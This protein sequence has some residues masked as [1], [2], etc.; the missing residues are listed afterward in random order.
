MPTCEWCIGAGRTK[1]QITEYYCYNSA[2]VKIFSLMAGGLGDATQHHSR[3]YKTQLLIACWRFD[4]MAPTGELVWRDCDANKPLRRI[5]E[6]I[7]ST[8]WDGLSTAFFSNGIGVPTI[9]NWS[10]KPPH[11]PS[12]QY[13]II[14]RAISAAEKRCGSRLKPRK[15]RIARRHKRGWSF[16][17]NYCEC[18]LAGPVYSL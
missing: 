17:R 18:W 14:R 5:H 15:C 16:K 6:A 8:A 4:A 12:G 9:V 11:W 1:F 2:W 3:P 10:G 7:L 13:L